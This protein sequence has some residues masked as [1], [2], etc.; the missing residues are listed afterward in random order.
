M[1]RVEPSDMSWSQNFPNRERLFL[2][3]WLNYFEKNDGHHTEVSYK[4]SQGLEKYIVTFDTL[5]I[6][7][8]RELIV[9]AT[10]IGD[11]GE[12]WF[13]KVPFVFNL[14][15]YLLPNVFADWGKGVHIQKFKPEWREPIKILQSYVTCEGRYAFVFKYHFR[16]LQH[17]NHESKMNLPFFSL[18]VCRRCLAE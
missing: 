14:E 11:E 9:E 6:E 16:F 8:T 18:R 17:L 2:V 5:K 7:L 1:N 15:N 12:Y 3:G 4:F 13:K 10:G